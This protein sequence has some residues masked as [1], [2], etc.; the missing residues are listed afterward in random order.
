MRRLRATLCRC[1]TRQAFTRLDGRYT[2]VNSRVFT[3]LE[4]TV[5]SQASQGEDTARG[6][7]DSDMPARGV[8]DGGSKP[9]SWLVRAFCAV[10]KRM[11]RRDGGGSKVQG[12]AEKDAAEDP[13][14]F[15]SDPASVSRLLQLA[16]PERKAL[17]I[18]VG[19]LFM[20]SSASLVFPAAVGRI[21]DSAIGEAAIY[22]P[23]QVGCC[24]C[25]W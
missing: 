11:P 15:A 7:G 2:R 3:L 19:T 1:H 10:S 24:C 6:Q 5:S 25:C 16:K 12:T 4:R 23:T 8:H 21:L 13:S 14:G 9:Q 22:T 18:A 20:T 17:S